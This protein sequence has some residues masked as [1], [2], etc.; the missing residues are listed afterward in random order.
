MFTAMA[1]AETAYAKAME[2]SFPQPSP[3]L[4]P[5]SPSSHFGPAKAP[6]P[7]ITVVSEAEV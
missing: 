7:P 4:P 3:S 2:V 1:A 5:S 6:F